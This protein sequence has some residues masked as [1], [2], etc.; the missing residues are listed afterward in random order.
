MLLFLE[1]IAEIDDLLLC[2]DYLILQCVKTDQVGLL[3]AVLMRASDQLWFKVVLATERAITI[4]PIWRDI[5]AWLWWSS[6]FAQSADSVFKVA[7][8][9]SFLHQSVRWASHLADWT[10]YLLS[11][12]LLLL[13]ALR[14]VLGADGA[15]EEFD[16]SWLRLF[17][18]TK[19]ER[20]FV[21]CLCEPVG[22]AEKMSLLSAT[23]T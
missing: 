17:E 15:L 10:S 20:W 4:T 3:V 8:L 14:L 23:S 12:K 1:C 18:F 9:I 21:L 19:L 11:V 7:V 6:N 22:D 13:F 16:V 5:R 2:D